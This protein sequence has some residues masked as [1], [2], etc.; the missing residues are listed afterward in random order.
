[1][2]V[3]VE[4]VDGC[5]GVMVVVVVVVVVRLVS[6]EECVCGQLLYVQVEEENESR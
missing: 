5:D 2:V 6:G 1:M 4:R 3:P